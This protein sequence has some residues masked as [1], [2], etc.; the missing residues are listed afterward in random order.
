MNELIVEDLHVNAED[1]EILK[2]VDLNVKKGEVTVIMGKNG[3]GKSTLANTMMG[4]PSY[5]VTS[6]RILFNGE[7]VTNMKAD[8]RAKRGLFLSFQYPSEVSGVSMANFLRTALNAVKGKSLGVMEFKKILDE[9]M[10]LLNMDK[11]F[12]FRYLND[13]FS[14]GEKKKGEI[15]QLAVLEPEISILDETDSG[16][17]ITSLREVAEGINKIKK[18]TGMGILLITHYDRILKYIKADTV[19]IMLDGRIVKSGGHEL[20]DY[21]EENGYNEFL[22]DS[23]EREV[24]T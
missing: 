22:R 16:L 21:I 1:K 10:A 2:G 23:K 4:N 9:R 20:A 19:H 15:L 24:R 7:D 18:Q 8:E 3:S 5:I 17:D 11:S 12:A 6:G 14:G 13:G